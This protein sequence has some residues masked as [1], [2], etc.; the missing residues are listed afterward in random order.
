MYALVNLTTRTFMNRVV[1]RSLLSR[2]QQQSQHLTE[3]DDFASR[4]SENLGDFRSKQISDRAE[5][6]A[7]ILITSLERTPR[8]C[9]RSDAN[10]LRVAD[11]SDEGFASPARLIE[12]IRESE[13]MRA[14]QQSDLVDSRQHMYFS[15]Q[16]T[17]TLLHSVTRMFHNA[18]THQRSVMKDFGETDFDE[19]LKNVDE[20][21]NDVEHIGEQF[22]ELSTNYGYL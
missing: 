14:L 19:E 3:E 4:S 21:R 20:S 12:R 5:A 8:K 16:C 18:C 15:D 7:R 9:S 2:S 10:W 22:K 13:S 11:N 1:S 17:E 6:G